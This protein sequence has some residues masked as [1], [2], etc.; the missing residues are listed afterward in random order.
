MVSDL[1]DKETLKNVVRERVD[2][3]DSWNIPYSYSIT[4]IK[5][6]TIEDVKLVNFPVKSTDDSNEFTYVPCYLVYKK[7]WDESTGNSSP[8]SYSSSVE[9]PCLLVNAIDGSLINIVDE[10]DEYPE[11]CNNNNT[12]YFAYISSSWERFQK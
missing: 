3:K 5:N 9:S 10:I 4:G 1:I 6:V 2:D 8:F 11:G 12:G 7:Y